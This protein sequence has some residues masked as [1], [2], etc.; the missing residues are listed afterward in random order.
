[1]RVSIGSA[2][3]RETDE[4]KAVYRMGVIKNIDKGQ[5][6]YKLTHF[7]GLIE[8]RLSVA[9]GKQ[10]K[11]NIKITLVSNSRVTP[12]E[13]E[14]YRSEIEKARGYK[15]MTKKEASAQLERMVK[16]VQHK[17][18]TVE[19][20]AMVHKKLGKKRG[21]EEQGGTNRGE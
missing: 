11:N 15:M 16:A 9:I 8:T 6:A 18:T 13:F 4:N 7:K 12:H 14:H 19:I 20:D 2:V 5:R 3:D 17:Y 1:M 21:I 10:V